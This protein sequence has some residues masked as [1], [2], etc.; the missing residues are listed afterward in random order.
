MYFSSELKLL[1]YWPPPA[2]LNVTTILP[3]PTATATGAARSCLCLQHSPT[4]L[5]LFPSAMN[6]PLFPLQWLPAPVAGTSLRLPP[7]AEQAT[8]A[9]QDPLPVAYSYGS[10]SKR[11]AAFAHNTDPHISFLVLL[12]LLRFYQF[13]TPRSRGRRSA[14]YCLRSLLYLTSPYSL[15]QQHHCSSHQMLLPRCHR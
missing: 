1:S 5:S 12:S 8:I 2:L 3:W 7:L 4:H 10:Q 9:L 11:N 13:P 14:W 15:L 6:N